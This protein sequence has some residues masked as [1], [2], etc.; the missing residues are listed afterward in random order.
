MSF[1]VEI[2]VL[3]KDTLNEEPQASWFKDCK[4]NS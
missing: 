4:K 3:Y 1:I 2:Q